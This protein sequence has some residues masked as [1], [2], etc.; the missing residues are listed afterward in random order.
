[1]TNTQTFKTKS[2]SQNK[3]TYLA[4]I[5]QNYGF[6]WEDNSVY[7]TDSKGNGLDFDLV[8]GLYISNLKHDFNEYKMTGYPTRI[9]KRKQLNK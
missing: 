4:V 7:L 9:I 2:I 8:N 6:G 3:Y 1:M 5:Q